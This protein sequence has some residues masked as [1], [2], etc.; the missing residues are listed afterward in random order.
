MQEG[1]RD[2]TTSSRSVVKGDSRGRDVRG[3]VG[4]NP[5]HQQESAMARDHPATYRRDTTDPPD[6]RPA[7]QVKDNAA[8]VKLNIAPRSIGANRKSEVRY[9]PYCRNSESVYGAITHQV[10]QSVVVGVENPT[11]HETWVGFVNILARQFSPHRL[12]KK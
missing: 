8:R 3:H 1:D 11:V 7:D 5:E 12:L 6:D 2:D 9:G 4:E 10:Q